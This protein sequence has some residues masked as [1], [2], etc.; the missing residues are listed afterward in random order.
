MPLITLPSSVLEDIIFL[1]NKNVIYVGKEAIAKLQS[2][3]C[4]YR[5]GGGTKTIDS[6]YGTCCMFGT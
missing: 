4:G 1:F 3:G 6:T 2:K 5:E